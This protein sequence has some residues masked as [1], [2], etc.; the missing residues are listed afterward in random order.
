[1][2]TIQQVLLA[3]FSIAAMERKTSLRLGKRGAELLT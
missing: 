3:R 2:A 1:L